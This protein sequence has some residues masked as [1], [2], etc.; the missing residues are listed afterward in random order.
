MDC[1]GGGL[2][3]QRLEGG[4]KHGGGDEGNVTQGKIKQGGI[5]GWQT[6]RCKNVGKV[7]KRV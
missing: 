2:Q 5:E 3:R 7:G 4:G 1:A 6:T